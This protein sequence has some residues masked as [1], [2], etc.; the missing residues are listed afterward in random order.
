MPGLRS[1]IEYFPLVT[2]C[3]SKS[4]SLSTIISDEL[5]NQLLLNETKFTKIEN[6]DK[7]L[8]KKD[9]IEESQLIKLVY[10][11]EFYNKFGPY[12]NTKFLKNKIFKDF[13]KSDNQLYTKIKLDDFISEIISN[14]VEF[15][16]KF[17]DISNNEIITYMSFHRLMC[18]YTCVLYENIIKSINNEEDMKYY[19]ETLKSRFGYNRHIFDPNLFINM[20]NF[21]DYFAM[22]LEILRVCNG[23]VKE[24]GRSEFESNKLCNFLNCLFY[25]F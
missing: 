16:N 9:E 10:A 4:S 14:K 13:L 7:N 20:Y 5:N 23:D 6:K 22:S 21:I 1:L 18:F 8:S 24:N 11:I 12:M 2:D 19:K 25:M 3:G 15:C 17:E